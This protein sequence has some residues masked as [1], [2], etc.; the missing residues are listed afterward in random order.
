[1]GDISGENDRLWRKYE[2]QIGKF[3]PNYQVEIIAAAKH[4]DDFNYYEI[5]LDDIEFYDCAPGSI[6]VDKSLDCDFELGFCDYKLDSSSDILWTRKANRSNSYFLTGPFSDHTTSYGYYALFKPT[7]FYQTNRMGRFFSS[8]QKP[9]INTE[10]CFSMWYVMFGADVNLLNVY[11]DSYDSI[12][13]KSNYSRK[14]IW[15]EQGNQGLKWLNANINIKSEKPWRIVIEAVTGEPSLENE[16]AVDDLSLK[17]GK[18]APQK[19]CHFK[20]S[21]DFCEFENLNDDGQ[22]DLKWILGRP[23]ETDRLF[24]STYRQVAYVDF[25]NSVLN[26]KAKLSSPIYNTNNS[27]A[28]CL[29][30]WYM[31]YSKQPNQVSLAVHLKQ[32]SNLNDEAKLL[33]IKPSTTDMEWKLAQYNLMEQS[34]SIIFQGQALTKLDQDNLN[35][36]VVAI[37]EFMITPGACKSVLD[38]DFEDLTICSWLQSKNDKLDWLF[39]Q[40]K[41]DTSSTGPDADRF[42]STTGVYIYLESSYPAVKGDRAILMSPNVDPVQEACFGLY[43]FM[44]GID[45]YQLNIFRNDTTNGFRLLSRLEG[46]QGYAWQQILLNISSPNTE[47]RLFLEGIVSFFID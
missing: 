30:F 22:V 42:N 2:F 41:T 33:F 36:A 11:I 27:N 15:T 1:L 19:Y 10:M 37:D 38:C 13:S 16:I 17:L 3:P 26:S 43:V 12:S 7:S 25:N 8:I 34:Y 21:D 39:N 4:V 14:I 20:N 47:Y 28:E 40:G 24:S 29:Q 45:V 35:N 46:E 18:C 32:Y 5:A 6:E 9:N 31:S 23:V 44:H